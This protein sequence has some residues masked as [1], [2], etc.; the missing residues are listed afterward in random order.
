MIDSVS[1]LTSIKSGVSDV[2]PHRREV[3]YQ[4]SCSSVEIQRLEMLHC[5]VRRNIRHN[6]SPKMRN[7]GGAQIHRWG[8]CAVM[9]ISFHRM[10]LGSCTKVTA[11]AA[12]RDG[13]GDGF[14]R[15]TAEGLS[16][17]LF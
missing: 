5:V 12:G 8:F 1:A 4:L 14:P 11:A 9:L 7:R 10:L 15:A 2:A 3:L 6:V 17:S 13:A 16:V